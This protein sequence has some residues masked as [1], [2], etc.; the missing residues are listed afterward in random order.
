MNVS[1]EGLALS[2]C[3][4]LYEDTDG[5]PMAWRQT[6]HGYLVRMAVEYGVDRGWLLL[7][8]RERNVCLTEEGRRL[9]RKTLS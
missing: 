1:T 7:N 4:Q 6:V 5:R 3:R 9:V 8:E 2:V